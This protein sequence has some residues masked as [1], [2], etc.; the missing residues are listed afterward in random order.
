[1]ISWSVG[2]RCSLTYRG[3]HV[4]KQ[5]AQ[6]IR[7][8]HGIED[9]MP[10]HYDHAASKILQL[11]KVVNLVLTH[12]NRATVLRILWKYLCFVCYRQEIRNQERT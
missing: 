3:Y 11:Y 6:G 12:L 10:N 8:E 1:M 7:L 2:Y 9:Y 4:T 5:I